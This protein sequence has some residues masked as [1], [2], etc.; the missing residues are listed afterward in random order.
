M[1]FHY[2][3]K[4]EGQHTVSSDPRRLSEDKE[5]RRAPHTRRV[6]GPQAGKEAGAG[7]SDPTARSGE[8]GG[9]ESRTDAP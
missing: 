7:E 5:T 1:R 6:P 3:I 8:S 4:N 2:I 9:E